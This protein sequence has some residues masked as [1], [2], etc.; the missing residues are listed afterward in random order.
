[1]TTRF[2]C[3]FAKKQGYDFAADSLQEFSEQLLEAVADAGED[4]FVAKAIDTPSIQVWSATSENFDNSQ[5][6]YYG[7]EEEAIDAFWRENRFSDSEA[8]RADPYARREKI[9]DD[10]IFGAMHA[11][12]C[13]YR[14]PALGI[15]GLA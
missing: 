5:T 3:V 7:T 13:G 1:M 11:A 6:G 10:L 2:Y 15:E 14:S 9:D 12:M 8:N 4:K